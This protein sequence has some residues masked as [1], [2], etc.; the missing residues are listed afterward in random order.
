MRYYLV[1]D[2]KVRLQF[3]REIML[4]NVN[5]QEVKIKNVKYS[6]DDKLIVT[7]A[8]TD[9]DNAFA[10]T[11]EGFVPWKNTITLTEIIGEHQYVFLGQIKRVKIFCIGYICLGDLPP[12][13]SIKVNKDQVI[14]YSQ[15]KDRENAVVEEKNDEIVIT[16]PSI[17]HH[18]FYYIGI[19]TL[20]GVKYIDS[21]QVDKYRLQWVLQDK[22][23]K[24]KIVYSIPKG[25][26]FWSGIEAYCYDNKELQ[27]SPLKA[28]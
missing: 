8:E 19:N 11:T 3:E 5:K 6:L 13:D 9:G 26:C 25:T 16:I 1:D 17:D 14:V 22:K 15:F 4:G 28:G 20:E 10:L 27:T 23:V 12:E 7:T 2:D 21:F 18:G 24:P